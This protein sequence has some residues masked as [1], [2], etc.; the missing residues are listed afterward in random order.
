MS[1]TSS[2]VM[3]IKFENHKIPEFKEVRN[4]E[5]ILFG[6]N[7][8]Y[9][10]YLIELYLRCAKH[11]AI[12]NGKCNYI[13]GGGLVVDDKTSTIQQ[14]AIAANYLWQWQ[15]FVRD[16][17]KDFEI[18]NSFAIEVIYNKAGK[19]IVEF[20]YIPISKIRT[21][22]DESLY[23]YSNDWNS[24]RQDEE[25][26][27]YKELQP[28][29][30]ENPGDKQLFVYKVT[31]PKNGVDKNVYA[32][33]EYIGATAAVE[34]DIEIANYHLNNIKSGFSAGT[35]INFN[36]GVPTEDA[37]KEIE[38]QIKKK[39]TGT[40]KAGGL[41]I[42]FNKSQENAPTITSFVPS[43][44][45]KQ[46]IEIGKRIDQEIF[47]SH[48]ITSPTLFGVATPGALG[49]R[50]EMIDA[51]ELFQST[52]VNIRQELLEGVINGF[53][54]LFGIASKIY[55]EK[56]TPVKSLLPESVLQKAYDSLS[57]DELREMVGL[58]KMKT[59]FLETK[60]IEYEILF[61]R[62]FSGQ[63]DEDCLET[64][65][66]QTFAEKLTSNEKAIVDL[67]GKEPLTP[68]D[69]LA[70]VLG[71]STK[72]VNNMIDDLVDRGYL[73]SAGD[74]T[75]KGNAAAKGAKTDGIEIKYRYG[76]RPGFDNSDKKTSRPFC[77]KWLEKTSD[78]SGW[79][80]RKQI[81]LKNNGQDLDVFESRGG[82]WNNGTA[83]L[84]YCRHLWYQ[85][86]IRKK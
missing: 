71:I 12:I 82:W 63:S 80:T 44:L 51:Y 79:L 54:K 40:D 9:P 32:I 30:F 24:Q 6:E 29:D 26:T 27:G 41:V 11:N 17:I 81:D 78:P 57:I 16:M 18:F 35:I 5:W 19:E 59:A 47:T 42:T 69:G 72:D 55:F 68:S 85:M 14:K 2:N 65:S 84:P 4:K 64:F 22:K 56:I 83:N 28:F 31:S 67:L 3:Y 77:V 61:E 49:Q 20:H 21:N 60:P 37:K 50:N 43:D 70:K 8:M 7:N 62:E 33:P 10:D 38:K 46:F 39:H 36:D 25:K 13:Y 75:Q 45:D 74:A 48:R 73:T 66:K 15:P 86:A 34:T 23:F 53:A 58:P 1:E 52:Y 76:W